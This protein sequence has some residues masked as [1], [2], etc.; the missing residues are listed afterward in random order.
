MHKHSRKNLSD[1]FN[2]YLATVKAIHSRTTRLALFDF[3]LFL[4]RHR[5]K[6]CREASNIKKSKSE[7]HYQK[8]YKL[9]GL[10]NLSK[11]HSQK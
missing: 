10:I 5:T 7:T 2:S 4:P 3:N 9:F 6:N 1:S 11:L 8:N